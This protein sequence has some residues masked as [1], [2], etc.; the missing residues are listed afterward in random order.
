MIRGMRPL[1]IIILI[2]ILA[3]TGACAQTTGPQET[4]S[5]EIKVAPGVAITPRNFPSHSAL[6]VDN[7]FQTAAKIADHSVFIY[8]WHELNMSVVRLMIEKS[9][10][11]GLKPILGL[12]PTTLD[13][14][15]KELDVPP[16]IRRKAGLAV[17][18]ANPVIRRAFKRTAKELARLRPAYLCLATEINFLAM[19]RLQEY[20]HFASLYKE[21]YEV[22]KQVSPETKV[23]VSF[24]WEWMR[25][26]DAKEPRKIKE[27][28][29]G[30]DIFRPQLDVVG[31]TTYPSP[32]HRLPEELPPD[33][34]LWMYHH[35]KSKDEVLLMEVGWPTQGSGSEVEQQA[36]IQ[37]LP[38]LL[39][40]VNVSVIA[41]A[42]LH[43]VDLAE[44]DAN[45]NSVGLITNSGQKKPGYT[46]F[47]KLRDAVR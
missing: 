41:W 29:K 4:E 17:S 40:R 8:Q 27:H 6:D 45:L 21:A 5:L 25:I 28:S 3:S 2:L 39:D 20:L 24:Q 47:K 30:I 31:L 12:S 16:D 7:A 36:F 42:L 14:G 9:K 32:F 10:K 34:Y 15:R 23:F 35:I 38:K 1:L 13:Q 44:F 37:R 22:V 18:F 46:E 19:Q 33:Y 11:A 26:I 43:D